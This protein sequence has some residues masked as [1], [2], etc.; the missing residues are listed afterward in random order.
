MGHQNAA[1]LLSESDLVIY[2]NHG[3]CHRLKVQN[4]IDYFKGTKMVHYQCFTTL[5][6]FVTQKG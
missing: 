1:V 2:S 5:V 6:L 4:K 3:T